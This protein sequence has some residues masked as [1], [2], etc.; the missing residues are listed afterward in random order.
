VPYNPPYDYDFANSDD[1]AKSRAEFFKKVDPFPGLPAALLSSEHVSDYVRVTGLLHP[2]Y[3]TDDRLKPAS[4]E[5]RAQRFVRWDDDG[6][7]IIT[8]VK[9]GETYELPEN[10][11]VFVQIESKIR[12]PDYIALR[13][14][15]RIKH[16]HRGLLLGTGPL[17]DPGFGG[18]LL[19]PLHNLTS[20]KYLIKVD[21]GIIWIEF[22]KTSH[23]EEKWPSD[24]GKFFP[25]QGHKTDV[26][27]S[28]YFER[29]NQNNPIQSSIPSAVKDA[30]EL[31]RS[32]DASAKK[33]VRTNRLYAS[34][35][36]LAIA[37]LMIG[38]ANLAVSIVR[39]AAQAASESR[40]ALGENE[41]LR[42]DLALS[43]HKIM[44][45]EN[46]VNGLGD[47]LNPT[48]QLNGVQ[49]PTPAPKSPQ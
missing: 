31:A 33:A 36:I 17:V 4:Y 11:I 10:S 1:E 29:A 14:N 8:D 23:N 15:L 19:I 49:P 12:L 16:V 39:D 43:D 30:R 24:R 2:F 21:E 7:K 47:K 40:R 34:I 37:G 18:D 22:T 38:L 26:P 5:A 42:R 27:F 48:P 6:R 13:F 20:K 45:L 9:I 28:T 32:A 35:G 25:I 46:R 44:E 41:A 3:P